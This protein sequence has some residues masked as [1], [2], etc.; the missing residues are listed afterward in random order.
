MFLLFH[1]CV[2]VRRASFLLFFALPWVPL[3]DTS[4]SQHPVNSPSQHPVNGPVRVKPAVATAKLP[5]SF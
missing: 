3:S 1:C 2:V 4:P 5:V